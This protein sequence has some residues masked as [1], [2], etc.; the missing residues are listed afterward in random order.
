MLCIVYLLYYVNKH[1]KKKNL[2]NRIVKTYKELC[3]I[4]NCHVCNIVKNAKLEWLT[5]M[6]A[7]IGPL[8]SII[9]STYVSNSRISYTL[10]LQYV[11]FKCYSIFGRQNFNFSALREYILA[12]CLGEISVTQNEVFIF[13]PY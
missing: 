12:A 13:V 3:E 2:K 5:K 1:K 4:V 10:F 8:V 7:H 11:C 6:P 9:G